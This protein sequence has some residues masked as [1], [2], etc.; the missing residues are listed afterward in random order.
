[1]VQEGEVALIQEPSL[2]LSD[3]VASDSVPQPEPVYGLILTP[4]PVPPSPEVRSEGNIGVSF[5]LCGLFMVFLVFA[6]RFRNNFKYIISMF[7]S[8]VETRTRQNV[9]DDTVSETSIIVIL[10]ILWCACAGVIGFC[11]YGYF[12]PSEVLWSH[13]AIGML[14]GMAVSGVYALFMWGAY[15]I[16]GWIFS[17][18]LHSELWVK[19]FSSSQ[20]LMAPAFFI[21]ALIGICQPFTALN[22]GIVSVVVFILVKIIFIWKGYRIFFNQISSWVLFL[23]YLCSLEI[24]PLVLCYRCAILL[25]EV[26]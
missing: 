2:T 24:V 7:K 5:I 22:V 14:L 13:R 10:N 3:S 20:A 4:P 23:C 16:V 19:G 25:G 18:R 15:S 1:M 17:D 26:L 12:Y 11:V 21:T 6:L 8:L 9:F